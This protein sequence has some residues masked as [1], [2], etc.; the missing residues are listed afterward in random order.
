MIE[1]TT[2]GLIKI[3]SFSAGVHSPLQ[4]LSVSCYFFKQMCESMAGLA[5]FNKVFSKN[6][7]H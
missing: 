6:F 3:Y 2:V 7:V 1:Y 4:F 5:S